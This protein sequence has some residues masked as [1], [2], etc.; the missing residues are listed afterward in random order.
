[1]KNIIVIGGMRSGT[2]SLFRY[3]SNSMEIAP[4]YIKELNYF[5]DHEFCSDSDYKQYFKS[6]SSIK[7]TLESSPVYLA[8]PEVFIRQVSLSEMAK[9]IVPVFIFRRKLERLE[10]VYYSTIRSGVISNVALEKFLNDAVHA[11]C[12][13]SYVESEH[14]EYM[15]GV[16]NVGQLESLRLIADSGLFEKVFWIDFDEMAANPVLVV[17]RLASFLEVN[18]FDFSFEIENKSIVP[19]FP[20]LY[21]IALKMNSTLEPLLN[22]T[23]AIRSFIR[24]FHHKINS[25]EKSSLVN[26]RLQ[27]ECELEDVAVLELFNNSNVFVKV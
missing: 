17:E 12:D 25:K 26:E 16:V 11:Q 15:N 27:R 2:T 8:L 20:I 1:M 19:K 14:R 22:R 18:I 7:Y 23:P 13:L 9:N 3:L 5:T 21:K 10:S 6:N 24:D 4:S